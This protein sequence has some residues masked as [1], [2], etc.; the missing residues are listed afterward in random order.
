MTN[1]LEGGREDT[2]PSVTARTRRG[3]IAVHTRDGQ[4][5]TPEGW[6]INRENRMAAS[7]H[8]Q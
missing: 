7:E 2:G 1:S 6:I 3:D 5:Q 8:R 4:A